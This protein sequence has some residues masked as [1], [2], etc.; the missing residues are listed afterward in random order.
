MRCIGDEPFYR[1][2]AE[3]SKRVSVKHIT[4]MGSRFEPY[5]SDHFTRRSRQLDSHPR[6]ERGLVRVQIP[7]PLPFLMWSCHIIGS[8]DSLINC[9][10]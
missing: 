4:R 7:R 3:S 6:F 8:I 10:H 2:D 1:S 9:A 5:R